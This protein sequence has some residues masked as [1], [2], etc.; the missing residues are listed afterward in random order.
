MLYIHISLFLLFHFN[1]NESYVQYAIIG[2]LMF[3]LLR[4]IHLS[5]IEIGFVE[6]R[7]VKVTE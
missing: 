3:V 2:V 7:I 6:L 1:N 5:N 4:V